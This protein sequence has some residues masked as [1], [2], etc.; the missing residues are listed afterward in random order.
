MHVQN[1][2]VRID[3]LA[4]HERHRSVCEQRGCICALVPLDLYQLNYS[5]QISSLSDRTENLHSVTIDT[6]TPEKMILPY[7]QAMR[8][9]NPIDV[10]FEKSSPASVD[11]VTP[12]KKNHAENDGTRSSCSTN[13]REDPC[14]VK[15]CEWQK[16]ECIHCE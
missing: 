12:S 9:E 13:I 6:M 16:Y 15:M 14:C 5:E 2:W 8:D 10:P 1:Q 11:N 4:T 3:I 7:L